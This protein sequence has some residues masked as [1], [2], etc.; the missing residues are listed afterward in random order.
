MLSRTSVHSLHPYFRHRL[1]FLRVKESVA[2][3]PFTFGS[4]S[5]VLEALVGAVSTGTAFSSCSSNGLSVSKGG[6]HTAEIPVEVSC[7]PTLDALGPSAGGLF[8]VHFRLD[9]LSA[10]LEGVSLL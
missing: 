7:A 5:S 3:V 10:P 9:F 6:S 1:V 2:K 8:L 4:L